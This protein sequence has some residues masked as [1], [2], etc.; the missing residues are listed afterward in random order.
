MLIC[1]KLLALNLPAGR[2]EWPW[3]VTQVA[4]GAALLKL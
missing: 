2:Q 4:E 3:R 1:V